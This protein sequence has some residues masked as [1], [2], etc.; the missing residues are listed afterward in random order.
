MSFPWFIRYLIRLIHL[1][2]EVEEAM[3][4]V[5]VRVKLILFGED[6]RWTCSVQINVVFFS[7]VDAIYS[8][9]RPRSLEHFQRSP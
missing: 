1:F 6:G 8:S 3:M 7:R 9:T 5:S 4:E 2:R